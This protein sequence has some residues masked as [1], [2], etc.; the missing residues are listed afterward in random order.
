MSIVCTCVQ[1]RIGIHTG[2]V[3]AAVLNKNMPHF[4]IFGHTVNK[5]SRMCTHGSY[6]KIHV[7]AETH[8]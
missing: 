7:S 2:P 6:G 4:C 3:V 5:A 8:E 1:V